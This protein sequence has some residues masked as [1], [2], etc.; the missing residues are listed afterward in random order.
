MPILYDPGLGRPV[1]YHLTVVGDDPD[2]Q[3]AATIALM[4]EYVRADWQHPLVINDAARAY[5]AQADGDPIAAVFWFVKRRLRFTADETILEPFRFPAGMPGIE[6]LIRPLDMALQPEGR[7]LGDC[8]D[9]VMYAAALLRG[10]GVESS[11]V[12]V[13]ADPADPRRYSHVYLAAYYGRRYQ[14]LAKA[15]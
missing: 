13:A 2:E 11:F 8:D 9:Y 12:T 1:N 6:A 10:L 4:R 5:S 15:Y 7:Q 3:V 14:R